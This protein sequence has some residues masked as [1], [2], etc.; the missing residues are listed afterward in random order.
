MSFRDDLKLIQ[1]EVLITKPKKK[2]KD[3]NENKDD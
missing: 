2:K 3:K 1:N